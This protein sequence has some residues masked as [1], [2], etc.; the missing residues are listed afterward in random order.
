M[1]GKTTAQI[2]K[3]TLID[4]QLRVRGIP[5]TWQSSIE[6]WEQNR[7]FVD[8]QVRGPYKLWHH[9][10]LFK[11]VAGGTMVTDRVRYAV[12]GGR[13]GAWL[14]GP[15]IRRDLRRVFAYRRASVPGLFS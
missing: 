10:H 6:A 4:Y 5:L 11:T 15:F 14:L 9:T 12:P 13:L 2:E 3:G 1:L 7:M 8:R